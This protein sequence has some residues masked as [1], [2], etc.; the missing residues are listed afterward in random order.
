MNIY[1]FS[2]AIAHS[3]F[4]PMYLPNLTFFHSSSDPPDLHLLRLVPRV[5]PPGLWGEQAAAVYR[6]REGNAL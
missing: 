5:S 6:E 2:L 3:L 4:D 1:V